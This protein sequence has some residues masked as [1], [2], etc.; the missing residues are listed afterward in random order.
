M[1]QLT[2]FSIVLFVISVTDES[3]AFIALDKISGYLPT[4]DLVKQVCNNIASLYDHIIQ[5][6]YSYASILLLQF[7]KFIQNHKDKLVNIFE[8]VQG[9]LENSVYELDWYNKNA[10]KI[11]KA[12]MNYNKSSQN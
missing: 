3:S 4:E 12:L 5:L 2:I 10:A 8:E 7:D 9:F 11:C 1:K 6:I